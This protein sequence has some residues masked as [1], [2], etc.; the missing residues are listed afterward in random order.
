ME[1]KVCVVTGANSGIGKETCIGL[2]G[3]GAHVV[4]VSRN[5]KR[6]E[7]AREEIRREA[8][9]PVDLVR[10]DLGSMDSVRALAKELARQYPQI[11]VLVSNAG[12]YRLRRKL[13]PDGYEEMF[14]VNHL[15]PFLLVNLMLDTLKRSAPARIVVVASAA[16]LSVRRLDF[17]NLQGE[18]GFGFG[19]QAYGRSKLGNIMFTYALSRRL[20]GTGVTANCLHPGAVATNLGSGNHLPN[21][22]FLRAAQL[23]IL[24]PAQGAQTPIY[25]AS[26]DE[27]EGTSGLYFDKKRPVPS[28][29]VSYDEEAQERLWRVSADLAGL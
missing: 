29:S 10:G 1:G 3:M 21:R 2:G 25:L 27:V 22:I 5:P 13:T 24:T 20:D 9:G 7:T 15:A 8:T 17:D 16:H 28:S 23:F 6:G 12:V 18:R 4:M 11:D 26:S 19:W 14:A